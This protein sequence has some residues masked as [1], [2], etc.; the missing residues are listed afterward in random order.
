MLLWKQE[1]CHLSHQLR[2]SSRAPRSEDL[3]LSY[4]YWKKNSYNSGE[5]NGNCKKLLTLFKR[6]S[7]RR[8]SQNSSPIKGF[9]HCVRPQWE[10]IL[11]LYFYSKNG[12]NSGANDRTGKKFLFVLK[13]TYKK[14]FL[15]YQVNPWFPSMCL[16]S[17]NAIFGGGRRKKNTKQNKKKVGKSIGARGSCQRARCPNDHVLLNVIKASTWDMKRW[18]MKQKV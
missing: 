9:L 11:E 5:N 15:K 1:N 12:H 8:F 4:F 14:V 6:L 3:L 13:T 10:W 17:R 16:A 2:V 18:E 7:V